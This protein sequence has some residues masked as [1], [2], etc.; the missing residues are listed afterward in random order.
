MFFETFFQQWKKKSEV[1][2]GNLT[3]TRAR[4]F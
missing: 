2:Q 1:S 3:T 4:Y